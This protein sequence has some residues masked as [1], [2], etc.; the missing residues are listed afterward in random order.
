[1][2]IVFLDIETT[3]LNYNEHEIVT[4]QLQEDNNLCEI[5]KIWESSE[6]EILEALMSRLLEIQKKGFSWCVG[7]NS[8]TFDIPFLISRCSFHNIET[9]I[10]LLEIFYRRLAHVDLR[11]ILLPEHK[12]QFKGLDW[13]YVLQLY[14]YP[15]KKGSGSQIPIWFKEGE[16][17]KIIDYIKSEFPPLVEIYWKIRKSSKLVLKLDNR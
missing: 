1:M 12:W 2:V 6:K 10:K 11:Q 9:S 13:D 5:Y 14:G 3:G 17:Q 4:I 7:F 8:L 16:Y 15:P